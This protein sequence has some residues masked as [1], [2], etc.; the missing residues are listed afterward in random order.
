MNDDTCPTPLGNHADNKSVKARK[1]LRD[2]IKLD[3][4]I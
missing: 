4:E 2:S 1:E 3:M